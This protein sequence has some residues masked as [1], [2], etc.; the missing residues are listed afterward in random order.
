[1]YK[2]LNCSVFGESIINWVKIFNTNFKASILQCGYL[3]EQYKIYRGC[4]QGDHIAP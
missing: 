3:S 1:M 2:I 4:R